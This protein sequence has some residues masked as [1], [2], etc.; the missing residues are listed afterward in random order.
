L[1]QAPDIYLYGALLQAAPY[2]QDDARINVWSQLYQS[3]IEQLTVADDRGA[4]SGGVLL[5]RAR[6]LG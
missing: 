5:T 4:S 2:L 1:T 6:T 3:G